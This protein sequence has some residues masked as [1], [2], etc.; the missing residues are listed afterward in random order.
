MKIQ[1]QI[2][3]SNLQLHRGDAEPFAAA[4]LGPAQPEVGLKKTCWFFFQV[5]TD[6]MEHESLDIR[7]LKEIDSWISVS[8]LSSIPLLYHYI[9]CVIV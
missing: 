9:H 6:D 7:E 2:L 4:E 1:P 5:S 8:F 3:C